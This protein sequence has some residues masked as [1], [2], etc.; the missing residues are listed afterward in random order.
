[1]EWA[2]AVV[3]FLSL[4]SFILHE[5]FSD[6]AKKAADDAAAADAEKKREDEQNAA[7]QHKLDQAASSS[8][9]ASNAWHAFDPPADP[10]GNAS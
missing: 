3:G 6:E 7:L 9:G 5:V 8:T 10:P 4:L 1:M 2:A